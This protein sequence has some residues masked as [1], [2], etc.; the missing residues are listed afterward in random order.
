MK[1]WEKRKRFHNE[2]NQKCIRLSKKYSVAF[3]LFLFKIFFTN[4]FGKNGSLWWKTLSL[5]K[6][7]FNKQHGL[8]KFLRLRYGYEERPYHGIN[9]WYLRLSF[10]P[11]YINYYFNEKECELT[12]TND[13]KYEK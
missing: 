1:N 3:D 6:K 13:M 7:I 11:I 9:W 8:R 12:I 4:L 2:G 10:L 5:K